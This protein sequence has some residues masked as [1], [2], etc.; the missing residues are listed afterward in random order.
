MLK[1]PS[2]QRAMTWC[3]RSSAWMPLA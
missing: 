3:E 2:P 1:P